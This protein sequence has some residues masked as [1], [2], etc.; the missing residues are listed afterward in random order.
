MTSFD[1]DGD[2]SDDLSL[3][4]TTT[5]KFTNLFDDIREKGESLTPESYAVSDMSDPTQESISPIVVPIIF[6]LIFVVGVVGNSLQV[7][8]V[9]G[10]ASLRRS[11]PNV[12]IAGLGVGDLLLLLISVPFA[13]TVYTLPGWSFGVAICKLSTG[14]YSASVAVSILTLTALSADRYVAIVRPLTAMRVSTLRRSLMVTAGIW[15]VAVGLSA[16]DFVAADVRTTHT[17]IMFCDPYPPEW[18]EW[19]ELFLPTFRFVALFVGPMFAI[20]AFYARIARVLMASRAIDG[21]NEVVS[22]PVVVAKLLDR[23]DHER[24]RVAKVTAAFL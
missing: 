9:V 11:P 22:T 4:T 21:S 23:Q 18:G 16:V 3:T 15:T 14:A 5:P 7:Y 6:S 12:L 20:G 1:Y 2:F 8:T 17:G 13:A 24:K 10:N 19:Y